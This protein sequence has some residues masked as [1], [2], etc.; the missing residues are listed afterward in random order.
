[1]RFRSP[2]RT[3]RRVVAVF[4]VLFAFFACEA[5]QRVLRADAEEAA[6]AESEIDPS[7]RDHWAFQPVRRPAMP[8]VTNTGWVRTPIDAFVLAKLEARGWSPSPEA[9][10]RA[11]LRRVYLDLIGLPPTPREQEA[12]LRDPSP[13]HFKQVVDALLARPGYGERWGRHWLDLVRYAETNG[14]ERD[15]TKPYVWRYRDWVIR[16]LNADKPYDRFLTEQLAGDE[17][18]DADAESLVAMGYFRLGPWDDEPADVAQDRFDQLDDIVSTTSQVVLGLTLGCARC[19]DHKFEPLVQHDYYRMVAVFNP[20]RRPL[21]GRTELTS[22]IGTPHEIARLAKRDRQ[23]EKLTA[24]IAEIREEFRKSY[25]ESDK[26]SLPAEVLAAFQAEAAKRD[27]AQKKLV[28]EHA[29]QLEEELAAALPEETRNQIAELEAK[30]N[31]L[32]QEVPDLPSGYFFVEPSAEAPATH[33][34]KRGQAAQPG[35]EVAPGVPVVLVSEQPEFLS[36]GERTTRR[37]LTLSRWITS[38]DNPLTARV[39]VNR[40]WQHHFGEGLVR[41]TSD[42]GTMGD[43]PTHPE[44]LDWLAHWFVHDAG[45]SL[46]KLH[47]LILTSSTYQMAKT[48]DPQYG[49]EDPENLMLWRVPYR[50]LEVEAI[51]DSMLAVSGRLNREMYGPSTYPF[52]PKEAMEGHS[53]PDKI[54]QPFEE[55]EASRRTIY[56]F[57]KRSL[58]VPMIEVLDFCDTTRTSPKRMT[59]SVAPQALTLLNGD[60]ANRQARHL[61]DRLLLE[62]GTD[63]KFLVDRAYL[64]ALCRPPTEVERNALT[65]FLEAE[66]DNFVATVGGQSG[67]AELRAARRGALVQMCRAILNL[68]EFVYTD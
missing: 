31:Q 65:R 5:P 30:E 63:A 1:M 6:S 62:V 48:W 47:R 39:I 25:L 2:A 7:A 68:N 64:L 51:R 54:W 61:A 67:P 49:A 34:L 59:T 46:K 14:Y 12:Y 37:R 38:P 23:I 11:I 4:A 18:P 53:D 10:P 3:S 60:F 26:S 42:F 33:L 43:E 13:E 45:W 50:R 19:H 22:P 44:L 52:V 8:E 58:I 29:K 21:G 41:S 24:E 57:V 16:S 56:A 9:E 55:T 27:D 36:P 17:L 20:L 40:V 32:R 66:T 28:E 35:P 15:G